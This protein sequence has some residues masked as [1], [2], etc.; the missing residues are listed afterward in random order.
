MRH[1]DGEGVGDGDR[2]THVGRQDAH[3][4]P[5]QAVPTQRVGQGHHQRHERDDFFDDAEERP[6][7]HKEEGDYQQ[8]E[9]FAP[10]E[11]PYQ[12]RQA[13]VQQAA[14]LQHSEG[15]PHQQQED[16]DNTDRQ[17]VR[18]PQHFHG[19]GEPAPDRV[20]GARDGLVGGRVDH[21]AALLLDPLIR[22]GRDGARQPARQEHEQQQDEQRLDEGPRADLDAG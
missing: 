7:A 9:I 21:Q 1:A 12:A 6:Q 22:P 20:V 16:Q 13:G 14:A 10:A 4:Q 8:Q 5:D 11:D 18:P 19:S 3:P 15:H 17:A 2:E